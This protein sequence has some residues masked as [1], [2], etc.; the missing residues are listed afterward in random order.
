MKLH[1]LIHTLQSLDPRLDV[2]VPWYE[3]GFNP[4]V[5]KDVRVIRGIVD[6]SRGADDY[7]GKIHRVG[8]P[9]GVIEGPEREFLAL[10]REPYE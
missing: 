2:V 7:Y 5:L 1:V 4:L 9:V 8:A 6:S 3:G 10:G